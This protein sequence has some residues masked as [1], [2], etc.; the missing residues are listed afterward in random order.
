MILKNIP[1]GSNVHCVEMK[2]GKGAQIA[3][4]AGTSA[5]LVA[6][7]GIYSTLRLQSGEMRKILSDCRATLG[8]VSNQEN[9]LKSIGKAGAN[10]W[11]GKRPTVRGVAMNPIDHP[12]GGG[13]G[14]T[15]GRLRQHHGV[16]TKGYKTRKN[17]RSDDLLLEEEEKEVIMPR[18]LKKDP[19]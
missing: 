9:N 8:V 6:K 16:P 17:S 14:R 10:R 1:L 13:E 3:R 18:S 12:H 11:R 15:G 19:L 2:P 4:S 5:R 7:E